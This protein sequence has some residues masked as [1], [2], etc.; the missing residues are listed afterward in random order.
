MLLSDVVMP[1][2]GGVELMREIVASGSMVPI[3]LASGYNMDIAEL[4]PEEQQ[5]IRFIAKPYHL[6]PLSCMIH[7]LLHPDRAPTN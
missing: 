3:I 5:R 2:L 4:S 1:E 7:E 6:G